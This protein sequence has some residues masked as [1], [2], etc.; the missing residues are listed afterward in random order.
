MLPSADRKVSGAL[1][2]LKFLYNNAGIA[3]MYIGEP[4]PPSLHSIIWKIRRTEEIKEV[5]VPHKNN[6]GSFQT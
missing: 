5:S 4:I 2:I 3:Y 1:A 6:I